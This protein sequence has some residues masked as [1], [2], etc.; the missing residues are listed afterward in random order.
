MNESNLKTKTLKKLKHELL[1]LI[2]Y[3]K[4]KFKN[5]EKCKK[6]KYIKT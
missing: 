4:F 1:N 3:S 5:D 2:Y 6:Y